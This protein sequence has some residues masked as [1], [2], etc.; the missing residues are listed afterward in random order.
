MMIRSLWKQTVLSRLTLLLIAGFLLQAQYAS[1]QFTITSF[2]VTNSAVATT[3]G[4]GAMTIVRDV[5]EQQPP[6]NI[7]G[8]PGY[9]IIAVVYG[10]SGAASSH[11]LVNSSVAANIT[12]PL[13]SQVGANVVSYDVTCE[14]I[15]YCQASVG[16]STNSSASLTFSP[17][18]GLAGTGGVNGAPI[19]RW[20]SPQ[21][22]NVTIDSTGH[23][24]LNGPALLAGQV[25]VGS[26]G[27]ANGSADLK[28]SKI[29]I[30]RIIP[31]FGA[32]QNFPP[33]P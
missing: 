21:R 24:V 27:P 2:K 25:G 16:T 23:G 13:P 18:V 19:S 30:S 12:G 8:G 1:A 17:D 7:F 32:P 22:I 15:A 9:H 29:Y 33:P 28:V 3:N 5:N 11:V 31:P 20:S 26:S 6:S 10:G 14:I 4:G